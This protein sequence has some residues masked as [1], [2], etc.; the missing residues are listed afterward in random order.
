MP[1]SFCTWFRFCSL[2]SAAYT[3]SGGT[4]PDFT[5]PPIIACP[6]LPQPINPIFLSIKRF[7][8]FSDAASALGTVF[9]FYFTAQAGE[10][11]G[12][13]PNLQ[14]IGMQR[15][16]LHTME[17]RM[18]GPDFSVKFPN[19]SKCLQKTVTLRQY[20][21]DNIR[22][23]DERP[24]HK[25]KTEIQFLIHMILLLKLTGWLEYQRSAGQTNE[26]SCRGHGLFLFYAPLVDFCRG[27]PNRSG[28]I[29]FEKRICSFRSNLSVYFL[30]AFLGYW[31]RSKNP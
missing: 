31:L 28:Q 5:I 3:C 22:K 1:Y 26:N 12:A 27:L 18:D 20:T 30:C 2:G 29:H 7:A 10:R 13:L 11:Q 15:F 24:E 25:I 6:M 23:G 9:S 8:P 16:L 4:R 17:W 14:K 21:K 19:F